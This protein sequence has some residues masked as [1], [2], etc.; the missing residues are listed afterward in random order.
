[1]ARAH[2]VSGYPFPCAPPVLQGSLKIVLV[3]V[4]GV[5]FG[6]FTLCMMCDQV[7][8]TQQPNHPT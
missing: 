6:L 7:S 1:M 3:V 2:S 8:R 4:E 5:L